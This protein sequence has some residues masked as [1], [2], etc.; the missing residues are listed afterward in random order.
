MHEDFLENV[1]MEPTG[2]LLRLLWE[3]FLGSSSVDSSYTSWWEFS[4]RA[5]F[6]SQIFI[7]H[8][9]AIAVIYVTLMIANQN[10]CCLGSSYLKKWLKTMVPWTVG[11]RDGQNFHQETLS[12]TEDSSDV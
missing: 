5:P 8:E 3:E 10:K 6:N 4:S 9:K 2:S 7:G 1:S 12:I 11:T